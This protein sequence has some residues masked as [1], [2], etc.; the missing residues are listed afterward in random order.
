MR[1]SGGE[2]LLGVGKGTNGWMISITA[3]LTATRAALDI[4]KIVMDKLNTADV[5]RHVVRASVSELLIHVVNAQVALGEA[6]VEISELRHKLDDLEAT[7]TL[8]ADLDYQKDGGY[9][10]RKSDG[11][12]CCPACWGDK[13]KVVPLAP[14]IN[15]GYRC[16]IHEAV[17]RR[18]DW[19]ERKK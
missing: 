14:I 18:P 5:D 15:E 13:K 12:F 6:N 2:L 4:A 9:Y 19:R 17:Y 16:P 11:A 3:G 1:R 7:K 10:L 8:E